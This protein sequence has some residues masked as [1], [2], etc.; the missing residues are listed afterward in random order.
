MS[1][2]AYRCPG[3]G[4]EVDLARTPLESGLLRLAVLGSRRLRPRVRRPAAARRGGAAARAVPARR[5]SRVGRRA[6]APARRA[7]LAHAGARPPRRTAAR[8]AG[9]R[10]GVRRRCA[11]LGRADELSKRGGAAR[12]L[13]GAA[14]ADVERR[15]DAAAAAGD[16]EEA[17]LLHA[18][19]IELGMVFAG[20]MAAGVAL[21]ARSCSTRVGARDRGRGGCS[22]PGEPVLALVSGGGDSTLLLHALTELGHPLEALHVAHALRGAESEADAGGL[23]RAGRRRSACRIAGRRRRSRPARTSR[24]ARARSGAPRGRAARRPRRRDGAHARRPGRDD[25]LPPR[26]LAGRPRRSRRCRRRRRTGACGRCSSSGRDEVRA[27]LRARRHPL[28][29]GLLEPRPPLRAQ[30]HPARPAAGLPLAAPGGRGEPPAPRPRCWPRTRR[31]S[32]QP[33]PACWTGR[34]ASTAAVAAA[35]RAALVRRALRLLAGL[36]RRPAPAAAERWAARA[37]ARR[38]GLGAARRAGAW[39]SAATTASLVV[40]AA[41]PRRS[42]ARVPLAVPGRH[43]VRRRRVRCAA[44]GRRRRARRRARAGG[45]CCAR[46]V[47]AS[48]SPGARR[49]IAAHAARG[50]ACRASERA[51]YPVVAVHGE[52]V[53][54]PGIAVAAGA[55]PTD[56]TRAHHRRP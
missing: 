39:P 22:R 7:R 30:P 56:W 43:A 25:P 50:A 19:Y 41:R 53:A 51:R 14:R 1:A 9:L 4:G 21:D 49:T 37:R 12:A 8:D 15:M 10:C 29:R 52:P 47:P 46:R 31:R 54:L 18:R 33:R 40:R 34:R 44:R 32:T 36:S 5:G 20:R 55:A 3:C 35:P 6:A 13:R 23:P 28:A 2:V 45:W 27:A 17:E 24:R 16:E 38:R 26:R 42:R 11:L 48:A